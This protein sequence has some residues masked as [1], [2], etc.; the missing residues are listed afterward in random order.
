MNK[1]KYNCQYCNKTF[2]IKRGRILLSKLELKQWLL[3]AQ[4][5]FCGKKLRDDRGMG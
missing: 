1:Q 5:P 4:C 3:K 2:N